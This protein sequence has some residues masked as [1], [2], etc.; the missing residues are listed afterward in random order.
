MFFLRPRFVQDRGLFYGSSRI[1]V[2]YILPSPFWPAEA[3]ETM[4]NKDAK[5]SEDSDV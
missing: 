4:A 5:V 3:P 2:E 1:T